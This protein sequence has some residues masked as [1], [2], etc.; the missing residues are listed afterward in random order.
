MKIC[1]YIVKHDSGLAPNPFWGYCTLGLC[2]PNHMGI[3]LNP[4]DWIVGFQSRTVNGK[5][6]Y[7][8]KVGERLH[9]NSYF[10]DERFQ[11]KKPATSA[12]WEKKCGDNMY[13]LGSDG[14]WQQVP[15]LMHSNAEQ[16]MQDT[17]HPYVY[18]GQQFYYFG[19]TAP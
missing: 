17:K 13:F 12:D 8:M 6:V 10:H 14:T 19:E 15:V 11:N 4:G 1:S 9:F 18:V 7:A 2:T 16:V 5:I 3:K